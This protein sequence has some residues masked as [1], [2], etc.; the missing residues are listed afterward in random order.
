MDV[1]SE[2][3][4]RVQFRSMVPGVAELSA[5]W[6]IALPPADFANAPPGAPAEVAEG[7]RHERPIGAAFHAVLGGH[8]VAMI[9]EEPAKKK[10]QKSTPA[11]TIELAGGDL[12]V[13]TRRVA[14]RICDDPATPCKPLHQVLPPGPPGRLR[15]VVRFGGGGD[16]TSLV[17]GLFLFRGAI[18]T[19]LVDGLPPVLHLRSSLHG[20]HTWMPDL[21]RLLVAEAS[22]PTAGSM[23][24]V[25]RLAQVL[26]CQAV[27]HHFRS[28]PTPANGKGNWLRA[29][30]DEDIGP[31]LALLHARMDEPWTVDSLA[32]EVA[33]SR[34]AF[35]SSFTTKVGVPPLQYLTQVRMNAACEMLAQ[36]DDSVKSIARTVGYASEAAFSTAFRRHQNAS[37]IEYRKAIHGMRAHMRS[38][39]EELE[40]AS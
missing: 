15:G 35:A 38:R 8:C 3:M 11:Q 17:F 33:M 36:G 40:M 14:H 30:L 2:A 5:P 20:T 4:E 9:D 13:I 37:P 28:A 21:L 32:R 25:N 29:S 10:G 39:H 18:G 1:L 19:Q 7:I 22:A 27:R 31:A 12:L 26:F 24:I 34:S 16:V 23:T 6:G